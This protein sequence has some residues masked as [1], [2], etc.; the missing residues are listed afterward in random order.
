MVKGGKRGGGGRWSWGTTGS[1]GGPESGL[2]GT[3]G[4][5]GVGGTEGT[6]CGRI[7]VRVAD[8]RLKSLAR[9]R[10][11]DGGLVKRVENGVG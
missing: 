8:G 2:Q 1:V 11:E 9:K 6:G 4:R 3:L 7:E 5:I 10:V